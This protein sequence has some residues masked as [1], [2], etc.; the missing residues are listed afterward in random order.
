MYEKVKQ[1]VDQ[2]FGKVSPHFERTVYWMKEL[3]PDADEAMFIA[4]YGHDI[5]RA[6]RKER[7][8]EKFFK[9]IELNNPDY[10]EEHQKVGAEMMAN[11][12]RKNK[13]NEKDVLRIYEMINLHETGGTPESD[14]LKDADSISYLEKEGLHNLKIIP[15]LGFD[16]I[17]NKIDWMYNRIS[18]KKAREF[19]K[20]F[21]KKITD[22]MKKYENN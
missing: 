8:P 2:S 18:S 6:F 3:K 7:S 5:H 17:K 20:P 12:L 14:I 11:F 19:A 10:I 15:I 16:K 21:Y 9:N 1:F 22:T 13:Y 4:A